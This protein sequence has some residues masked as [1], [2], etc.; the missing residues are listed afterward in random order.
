MNN[1]TTKIGVQLMPLI[2]VL[3]ALGFWMLQAYSYSI[4]CFSLSLFMWI[5]LYAEHLQK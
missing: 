3:A 5:M 1:K 4:V 2:L